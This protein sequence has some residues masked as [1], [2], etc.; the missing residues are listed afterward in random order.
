MIKKYFRYWFSGLIIFLIILG[1]LVLR[2]SNLNS[3]PIFV[4]EAIY[5]RWAQVMQA[6]STLR[7]L[8]LSD[9]KQP[10]FMWTVIPFLKIFSDPLF[11]GRFTSVLTGMGILLGVGVL[12]HLLFKSR[13]AVFFAMFLTAISP[14]SVFFDRMALV[15]SMLAMFGLWS[16][17]L[18][19]LTVRLLRLDMAMFMG[20][21]LGGA[22]LTK[23]PAL[24]FQLL[25]PTS[26]IATSW[27]KTLKSKI[28]KLLKISGLFVVSYGISQIMFNIL[29]LGPNF[30]LLTSRN[31]DYVY[32]Y[33]H[34]FE[35]FLDPFVPHLKDVFNW[36]RYYG[37]WPLF[38][39][40]LI[41]LAIGIKRYK[42]ETLLLFIFILVPTFAQ[43]FYAKVFTARYLYFVIPYL[44]VLSS[45][46][47][48]IKSK[49]LKKGIFLVLLLYS[50]VALKQDI[51]LI[52]NPEKMNFPRGERTG[53]LEEWTAGQGIPEAA[54]HIRNEY[55]KDSSKKI[56]VGTDGYFGTLPDGLQIYLNDLP[57]ITVV[58]VEVRFI[59]V[60]KPLLESAKAGN[61]TYLLVN[62]SRFYIKDPEESGLRL[63]GSYPRATK[64]DGTRESLLFF[65]VSLVK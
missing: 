43:C 37:P 21:S 44:F 29:R 16:L 52:I 38:I 62:S 8:P 48:L 12:A 26:I 23:S 60:P 39:F 32:P 58:G 45:L 56:V 9:G 19:I 14:Y 17:I 11:A 1:A 64:P 50:F 15:D 22:L 49:I 51:F 63:I 42:K 46:V 25:L 40:I 54:A 36:I 55:F 2:L 10:L 24:F 35:N 27:P 33:N 41:A 7:F 31:Y 13:K 34:I 53:Y 6:E 59:E 5:V 3:L 20:F 57:A 30:H 47:V 65:E 18:A 4:D 28:I 61:K